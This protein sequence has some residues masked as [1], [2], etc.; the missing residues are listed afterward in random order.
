MKILIVRHGIAVEREDFKLSNDDL[1][2]LTSQGKKEFAKLSKYYKKLYPNLQHLY[3]SSLVRAVQTSEILSK[4]FKKKIHIIEE[5]RPEC[6]AKDLLKKI[7]TDENNFIAIVGHEP[8]L[9]RFIG[10]VVTGKSESI[11]ELKKG[12]ACLIEVEET[13][14]IITLHTPKSLLM[15]KIN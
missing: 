2:P 1:R 15:L 14:R 3:S 13:S 12:G 5:L 6:A 7:K 11:V 9:T 4:T 10:Y 8:A